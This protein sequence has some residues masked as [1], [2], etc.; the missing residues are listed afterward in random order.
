MTKEIFRCPV[1][2]NSMTEPI[3]KRPG[4]RRCKNCHAI[5][6]EGKA[7]KKQDKTPNKQLTERIRKSIAGID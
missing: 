3:D 6:N 1:C 4:M 7:R 5:F 2:K